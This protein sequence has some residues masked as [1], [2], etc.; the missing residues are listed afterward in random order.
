MKTEGGRV[1]VLAKGSGSFESTGIALW[2]LSPTQA[3]K[4]NLTRHFLIQKDR[5]GRE[6]RTREAKRIMERRKSCAS[7]E[8]VRL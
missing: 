3:D 5:E 7:A 4:D 2:A 8:R 6:Q 1:I